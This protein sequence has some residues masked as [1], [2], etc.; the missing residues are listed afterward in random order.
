MFASIPLPKRFAWGLLVLL[1]GCTQST[2]FRSASVND[3][4]CEVCTLNDQPVLVLLADDCARSTAQ[5]GVSPLFQGKFVA[6]G[7]DEVVW[8]YNKSSGD[9]ATVSIEL[10]TFDTRQGKWF[11]ITPSA[12]GAEVVQFHA[13]TKGLNQ[14]PEGQ[15]FE[16]LRALAEKNE[17]IAAF[18]AE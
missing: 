10:Q 12:A 18:L 1:C 4:F 2:G 14:A 11:R 9:G 15:L 7:G 17:T 13:D 8:T 16:Q 6:T 5:T 3:K